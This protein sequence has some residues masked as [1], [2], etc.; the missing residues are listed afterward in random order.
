MALTT[1]ERIKILRKEQKLTQ[2][3]LAAR[4]GYT[5]H[6][7]ITRIE[8]GK[9]DLPQSRIAQFAKVLGVTPGHLL[10][11]EAEPEDLGAVAAQVLADPGLLKLVQNYMALSD[12]DQYALRLMAESLAAKIKK[13]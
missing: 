11:W 7:T 13:D 3:E 4:M 2:R 1:G 6:T 10:G 9:V 12:A 5:D 8:A